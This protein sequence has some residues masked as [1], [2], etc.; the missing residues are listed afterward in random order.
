[1]AAIGAIFP[2]KLTHPGTVVIAEAATIAGILDTVDTGS[3][4]GA[5]ITKYFWKLWLFH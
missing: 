1:M 2:H 3:I 5:R 4:S